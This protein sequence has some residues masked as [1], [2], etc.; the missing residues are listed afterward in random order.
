MVLFCYQRENMK[1]GGGGEF[2]KWNIYKDD[3]EMG[4]GILLFD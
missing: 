4:V 2:S 1:K 3:V